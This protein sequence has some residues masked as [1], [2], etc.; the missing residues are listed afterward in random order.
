MFSPLLLFRPSYGSEKRRCWRADVVDA[1]AEG[2]SEGVGKAVGEG[3]GDWSTA[4]LLVG[5]DA[6]NIMSA[7][8]C[9][10]LSARFVLRTSAA[11]R[12]RRIAGC[13]EPQISHNIGFQA[14]ISSQSAWPIRGLR[15]TDSVGWVGAENGRAT[16]PK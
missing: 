11:E 7:V 8:T 1:D 13:L 6:S 3:E 16:V 9:S 15:R 12:T 4:L 5:G 14:P 10:P 2:E